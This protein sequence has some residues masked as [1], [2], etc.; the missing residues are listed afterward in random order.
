MI[1]RAKLAAI[2]VAL[3][4]ENTNSHLKILAGSSFCINTIKN[5]IIDPTSYKHPL[6]KD[7]LHLTDQLLRARNTKQMQTYIEKVKSHTDIKYNESADTA[8]RAVLDGVVPP[9]IT[10]DEE[11]PHHRGPPHMV[12]NK[13]HKTKHIGHH[14]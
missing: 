7:F 8:A 13:A 3:R 4:Q 14:S 9:D 2:T 1:D 6:H 10:F 12:T 11:D 5:Y